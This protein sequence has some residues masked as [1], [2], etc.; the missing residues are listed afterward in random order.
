MEVFIVLV[1]DRHA[2]VDAL[3]F[4]TWG[5][6]AGCARDK[7]G[8]EAVESGLTERSRQ[9]GVVLLLEYGTEGDCVSVVRRVVDEG[10]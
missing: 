7:A 5:R 6:A 4:S 9:A 10:G 8:E 2:D 1:E 3:P